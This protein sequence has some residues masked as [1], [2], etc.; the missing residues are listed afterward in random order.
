MRKKIEA[1]LQLILASRHNRKSFFFFK[2]EKAGAR[3][4]KP[5]K[6]CEENSLR[7]LCV[8]ASLRAL[9]LLLFFLP[10]KASAQDYG[11][12]KLASG[13]GMQL[14]TDARGVALADYDKDGLLDVFISKSG[15]PNRLFRNLGALQF[16]D[17]AQS[18]GVAAVGDNRVGAWAD[19]DND[20]FVDLFAGGMRSYYLYHNRG[21]GTFEELSNALGLKASTN[22]CAALW[23]D[24]ENNGRL[25]LYT[26]NL[27]A[28]NTFF[29][30]LADGAFRNEIAAAG[31]LDPDEPSMGGA[32][33]DY[34]NDGDRDLYLVHDAR[35]RFRLYRNAGYGSFSNVA[36]GARV[37]YAG[38]GMGT[39]FADF[40]NDGWLD[41]YVTNLDTN[42]I[43]FNN[44]NGT[45]TNTT[46]F[47]GVGDR[48][49][50]WGIVVLDY[51]NDMWQDI[52]VVNGSGFPPLFLDNVLYRNLGNRKFGIVTNKA[53]VSSKLD[54]WCGAAG[55]LNNDGYQD[56]VI[57]NWTGECVQTFINKAGANHYLKI[58]LAG[59]QC[60]RYAIGARV[61][62][63]ANGVQQIR[64]LSGGAGYMSQD[65]PILHFGMAQATKADLVE[66]SWPGG[67]TERYYDVPVNQQVNYVEGQA[68]AV[69]ESPISLPTS[70]KL[71]PSYPNPFAMNA[72]SM[73]AEIV[74]PFE[75]PIA[76]EVEISVFDVQGR[77]VAT[78]FDGVKNS[79]T[80]RLVWNGRDASGNAVSAGIYFVQM[81]SAGQRMN[82]KVTM[83]R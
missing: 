66:I 36:N 16:Q 61:K 32:F 25:D 56:M 26:A 17:V 23:S 50:G 49:M 38:Q 12:T 79:G 48:G 42:A 55:D 31:L 51:D 46:M 77:R 15:G 37:D 9:L 81:K 14:Q 18:A 73:R 35:K 75:L 68:T 39:T 58:A 45:F 60:N 6:A 24:V 52:Y 70:L 11:F 63:V 41:L 74:I 34:D 27:N 71:H 30:H 59:V 5:A 65:S 22:I 1:C 82:Q 13:S 80:H 78:L 47:S 2:K 4:R 62:V 28:E 10:P 69:A 57:T 40:D 83:L 20:G 72:S 7:P 53:G 29:L 64:E 43:F 67:K 8:S 19:Y 54:G 44:G 33:G 76:S 3:S 21:N